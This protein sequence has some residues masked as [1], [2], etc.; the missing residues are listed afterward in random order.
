[1][2]FFNL[3]EF[4]ENEYLTFDVQENIPLHIKNLL[5]I[6]G[7]SF[8]ATYQLFPVTNDSVRLV[9]KL[10]LNYKT[11]FSRWMI[12]LVDFGDYIMMR[13]Q[14][15]NFK[16]LAENKDRKERRSEGGIRM[17]SERSTMFPWG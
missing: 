11:N 5:K 12:K 4:K 3:I 9:V 7:T 13:R 1:M 17:Y 8:Y 2:V 6:F 16:K 10:V 14:L 15:L